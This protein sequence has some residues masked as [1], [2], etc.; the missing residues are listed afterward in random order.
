MFNRIRAADLGY[1]FGGTP[2]ISYAE[3][4]QLSITPNFDTETLNSIALWADGGTITTVGG[5]P[6]R[7]TLQLRA[8]ATNYPGEQAFLTVP[9]DNTQSNAKSNKLVVND[10]VVADSYKTDMRITGRFLNYRIDDAAP[11]TSSSY[12]G[13]NVKAWNLSGL[14]LGVMKGG[15]K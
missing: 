6:Q 12:T 13:S 15:V 10:F 1:D 7:A 2:Y 8:R 4:E 9:E 5:Q 11:D 3:R 14:Q